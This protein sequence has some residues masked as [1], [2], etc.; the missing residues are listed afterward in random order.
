MEE[1][2]S[3]TEVILPMYGSKFKYNEPQKKSK[4]N[5]TKVVSVVIQKIVN[6]YI[7]KRE[8]LEKKFKDSTASCD[9][10]F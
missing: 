5:Y 6:N 10:F 7:I 4:Y 8:K 1:I 9:K 3:I 2:I